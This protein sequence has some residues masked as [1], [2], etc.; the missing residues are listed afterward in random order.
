MSSLLLLGLGDGGGV[1]PP[2]DASRDHALVVAVAAALEATGHFDVVLR[3]DP[4]EKAPA[5]A[6]SFA[7]VSLSGGQAES[8]V[9]VSADGDDA[10]VVER[11]ELELTLVVADED[12]ERRAER[13]ALLLAHA[14]VAIDGQDFGGKSI[15]AMT[16][17]VRWRYARSQPPYKAVVAVVRY[18]LIQVGT[19]GADTTDTIDWL[20]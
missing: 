4:T 16:L 17:I 3:C 1:A 18:A 20:A 11:G 7:F 14:K 5:Q 8:E 15:G 10:D 19:D 6:S 2:A 12:P 9:S 13:L